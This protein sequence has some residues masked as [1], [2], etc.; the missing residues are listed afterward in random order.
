MTTRRSAIAAL[1]GAPA[2]LRAQSAR[3]PNILW[4]SAEDVSP[5][6]G[7]YGDRYA[8]TPN[9]DRLASEGQRYDQAYSVYPVCAPSR[10]SIITGMYPASIGSHHMRSLAVPPPYV[11]CFPEYLRAAGYYCTNNVK[12]D[13][14]FGLGNAVP[15]GAWDESSNTAHWRNRKDPNQPFFS[16]INITTSHE[17][18]IRDLRT[19]ATKK[20][21]ERYRAQGGTLHDPAEAKVPPYYPDTPVVRRDIANYY[22]IVSAMDLQ[23]GEILKQLDDDG[24]RDNTI[25]FHWG[26]HGWGMP[27]G[28]RWIYDSGTHVP[29]I[30]RWPGT[31]RPGSSTDELVSLMDLGPTT[32]SLAGLPVPSH[33]QAQAFLGP[34]K[35]TREFVFMAR[36]RMDE[37]YDMM[38]AVRDKRYRYIRNYQPQKPFVQYVGYMD[39]MPTM[40]EMRRVYKEAMSNGPQGPAAKNL[41][42]GMKPFFSP[43]KPVE[44]LYDSVS[45]P[46]EIRNLAAEPAHRATLERMR[47]VHLKFMKDTK[48]LGEMPENELVERMRPG[49]VWQTTAKP[50]LSLQGGRVAAKCPTEGSTIVYTT[51][52]GDKP[53][54][55]LYT[56]P[57]E[58][59]SGAALRFKAGRI[60]YRDSEEVS[61]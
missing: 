60:G 9:L 12:T 56:S 26:D 5:T 8:V 1:A 46:H 19:E 54:W 59:Q 48:D 57:A 31:L 29:L 21:I 22:D 39:A 43:E 7:C 51:E 14:N 38:R 32:L 58:T 15:L 24:L 37:T 27:R 53:Y 61:R 13:Y 49:G 33:M 6:Y 11:K 42:D 28:K 52:S 25:V 40:G 4:I 55:R 10:S 41:P 23:M 35:R 45:D 16:V 20:V 36:D 30:V 44:E 47:A 34:Q 3:R 50:E 18:Q 2:I 17:S